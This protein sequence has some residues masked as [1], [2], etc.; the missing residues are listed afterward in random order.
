M[1]GLESFIH[2][3]VISGDVG[4]RKPDAAIY[5]PLFRQVGVEPQQMIFVDDRKPN[6]DAAKAVG[7]KTVLVTLDE[8]PADTGH[9]AVRG[10]AELHHLLTS[11]Q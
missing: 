5:Q 4:V 3:F 7:M 8:A 2:G 10:F 1:F 11:T 6:L 9:P